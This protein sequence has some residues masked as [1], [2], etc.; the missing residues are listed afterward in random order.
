MI[1]TFKA[2]YKIMMQSIL[3]ECS[4]RRERRG[5]GLCVV[6]IIKVIRTITLSSIL[7]VEH[8]G[9]GEEERRGQQLSVSDIYC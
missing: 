8:F 2:Q 5:R 9:R 6:A 7:L 1:K 3:P 4:A